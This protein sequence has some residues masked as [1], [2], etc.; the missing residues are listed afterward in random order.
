[1]PLVDN[2]TV[3]RKTD[4]DEH[5]RRVGLL[6][7]ALESGAFPTT[8]AS[9]AGISPSTLSKWLREGQSL[10]EIRDM[11]EADPDDEREASPAELELIWLAEQVEVSEAQAEQHLT[12]TVYQAAEE[13]WR[14]AL[15]LMERRW[16]M[17]WAKRSEVTGADGGALQVDDTAQ[18]RRAVEQAIEQVADRLE[19]AE[20]AVDGSD[21]AE[22]VEITRENREAAA[23]EGDRED[24]EEAG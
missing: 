5:E 8:A 15:A 17:R 22:V 6:R 16:K 7:T 2:S 12:S 10:R 21:R 11:V 24:D 18:R 14:A 4:P 1:M 19:K 3:I 20:K 23:A 9:Y 13:D